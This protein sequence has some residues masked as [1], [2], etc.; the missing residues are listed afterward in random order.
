[1]PDKLF[2]DLLPFDTTPAR[3][4]RDLIRGLNKIPYPADPFF[5]ERPKKRLI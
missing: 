5:G 4:N 1:M 3:Q 2:N